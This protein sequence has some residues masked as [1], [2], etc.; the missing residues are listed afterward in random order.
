MYIE[1]A[2]A[3]IHSEGFDKDEA[4]AVLMRKKMIG[5]EKG[6]YFMKAIEAGRLALRVVGNSPDRQIRFPH[7]HRRSVGRVMCLL[8]HVVGCVQLRLEKLSNAVG[9]VAPTDC[10][11]NVAGVLSAEQ[12]DVVV[13]ECAAVMVYRRSQTLHLVENMD[14]TGIFDGV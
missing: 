12:I 11:G 2:R 14:M 4:L 3:A 8:P 9:P 10:K 5:I 1:L 7:L 13:C 6:I